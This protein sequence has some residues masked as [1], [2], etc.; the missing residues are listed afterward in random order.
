MVGIRLSCNERGFSLIELTIVMIVAG[1]MLAMAMQSMTVSVNNARQ[2]RTEREMVMLSEAIVGNA[3]NSP[4]GALTDFG[5]VGDIGSFPGDLQALYENSYADPNWDGPYIEPGFTQDSTGFK[6]DEWGKPY[7]YTGGTEIVST[8]SGSTISSRFARSTSDYLFNNLTGI[9]RDRN[10][11]LPGIILADSVIVEI[12]FPN[13]A[14]GVT[15]KTTSPNSLGWFSL[16][17]LPVGTHPVRIIYTPDVDSLR[18]FVTIFPRHKS[19]SK[20][21]LFA[22]DHFSGGGGGGGGCSGS[23]SFTLRPNGVGS[24]NG[25]TSTGCATNW[26]CVSETV[27]DDGSTTV[28]RA[29]G[30][31]ATD[32]YTCEDPSDT[33]CTITNVTVYT[34][35]SKSSGPGKI[36][37]TLYLGGTEYNGSESSLTGVWVNYSQAWA[38]SPATGIGWTWTEIINLE[39]GV[40]LK[41]QSA[42]K[43]GLCTQVW[44]VV[45]YSN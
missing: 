17:S 22:S 39:A 33:N 27:A 16:D 3:T 28:E 42:T 19:N 12:D 32:S 41:G 1:I 35:A 29:A 25:L 10:D 21:Y 38:N 2:V 9:I 26:Q 18:R 36:Q 23:G 34:R 43:L 8:G 15:T 40:A 31:Y 37:P 5:Y 7:N 11:S 13:G 14:G 4:S 30:S 44:V 24:L 45:E 20:P 6:N